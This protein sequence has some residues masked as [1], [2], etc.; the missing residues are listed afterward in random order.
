MKKTLITIVIL[1]S[2]LNVSAYAGTIY[3]PRQLNSMV[4]SGQ[5]PNQGAVVDN[6]TKNMT[7]CSCK[8]AVDNVMS[9]LRGVYPVKTIV[10]TTVFYSIK[11]WTND[12]AVTASCSKPDSKMVMT[13]ALYK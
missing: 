7:F 3:T 5:Y 6:Q 1:V 9:T 2:T 10:D 8:V 11:A 12:G 4:D 13:R